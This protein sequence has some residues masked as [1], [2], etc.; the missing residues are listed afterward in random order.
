MI[1]EAAGAA[2]PLS[3]ILISGLVIAEILVVIVV[4]QRAVYVVA[5]LLQLGG[6]T[7]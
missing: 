4:V 1:F 5:D 2:G 3:P 6:L 7:E